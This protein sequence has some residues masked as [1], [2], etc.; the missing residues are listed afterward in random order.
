MVSFV[1]ASVSGTKSKSTSNDTRYG[2]KK[3]SSYNN[4]KS[5]SKS[6]FE[7][8]LCK[9]ANT[10]FDHLY[11]YDTAD[12]TFYTKNPTNKNNIENIPN[13]GKKTVHSIKL[14]NV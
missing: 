7:K 3:I 9:K 10:R 6:D 12:Q 11:E 2:G 4:G 13:D 1:T 5:G 14:Y 8:I